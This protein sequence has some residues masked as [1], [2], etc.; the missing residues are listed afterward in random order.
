MVHEL[1]ELTAHC[2]EVE[3]QRDEEAENCQ[4]LKVPLHILCS[5]LGLYWSS[6][7]SPTAG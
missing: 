5:K 3:R 1:N 2:E 4:L 7:V 6:V